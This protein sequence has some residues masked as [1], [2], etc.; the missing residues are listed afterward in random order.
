MLG[1]EIQQSLH[2][3]EQ[4]L[5][6][7]DLPNE[8]TVES[9]ESVAQNR[10]TPRR[11]VENVIVRLRPSNLSQRS[12]EEISGRCKNFSRSG[13][14]IITDF[15]PRVGDI[16]NIEIPSDSN[17]PL[18]GVDARCV[19]CHLLDADAFD[20]GFSFLATVSTSKAQTKQS[21]GPLDPLL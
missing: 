21:T 4:Q 3:L 14:G 19:R 6:T 16:Y 9:Q 13:C 2:L 15:A 5:A 18:H 1:E 7:N 10:Q 8:S 12:L 20:C 11:R 17:H